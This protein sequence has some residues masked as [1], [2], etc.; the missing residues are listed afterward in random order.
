MKNSI[1]SKTDMG[2][3]RARIRKIAAVSAVIGVTIA[4]AGGTSL[5]RHNDDGDHGHGHYQHH[6]WHGRDWDDRPG[7]VYNGPDYYYAPPPEYYYQPDPYEY[8]PP[9]PDYYPPPPNGISQF[10]GLL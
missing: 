2:C 1:R 4:F 10:F 3:W 8:Y 6:E 7:Y 5:A 9:Q